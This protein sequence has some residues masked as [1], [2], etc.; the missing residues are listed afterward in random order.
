MTAVNL[1]TLPPNC[2][3]KFRGMVSGWERKKKP[4]LPVLEKT[5]APD[6]ADPPASSPPPPALLLSLSPS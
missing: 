4:I 6:P 5:T 1:D 3:V 2:L